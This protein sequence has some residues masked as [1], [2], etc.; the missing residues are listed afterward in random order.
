Y[1]HQRDVY[2]DDPFTDEVEPSIPYSLGVLVRNQGAGVA[3]ALRI[4]S[5]QP[6]IIDNEKGLLIDFNLIAAQVAG[7][8][9]TPSLSLDLGDIAPGEVKLGQWFFTS[10][11][12]GHFIDYQASFTHLD[13]LGI[14]TSLIDEVRIHEM[15]RPVRALGDVDDGLF[16]F[17]VNDDGDDPGLPDTL[18]LSDGSIAPV[19]MAEGGSSFD[20]PPSDGDLE[21]ELRVDMGA[22]YRYLRAPDP[23]GAGYR[24]VAVTRS[25]GLELPLGV[26]AWQTDRTFPGVQ[27]DPVR[28]H[29]LHLFDRDSTGRYTLRYE[30]VGEGGGG[31]AMLPI[32][33]QVVVEGAT[34]SLRARLAPGAGPA[35]F[36]LADG[37]PE[38]ARIDPASGVFSWTPDESQGPG[39]YPVTV[40]A[41]RG[42]GLA[43]G[44]VAFRVTVNEGNQA[45]VLTEVAPWVALAGSP[46]TFEVQAEDADL[47][48]NRLRFT[49]GDEAPDGAT[50]DALSG[51]FSW[52]TTLADAGTHRFDVSVTDDGSPAASDTRR[53]E[54]RL[55]SPPAY[56]AG[57]F[58]GLHCD[59]ALCA[60]VSLAGSGEVRSVGDLP[61]QVDCRD[62]SGDTRTIAPT[63][64]GAL[65]F[66]A[67][68]RLWTLV[69][70]SG[71]GDGRRYLLRL[72]PRDASVLACRELTLADG[73]VLGDVT[74]LSAL[75]AGGRL[76][77]S[78]ANGAVVAFDPL[79][80]QP[81]SRLEVVLDGATSAL[82]SGP[83]GGDAFRVVV[84]GARL[85]GFSCDGECGADGVIDMLPVGPVFDDGGALS[86]LRGL[87]AG[88]DGDLFAFDANRDAL[89][90]I[91]AA[92][93]LVTQQA[94]LYGAAERDLRGLSEALSRIT[95]SG[96]SQAGVLHMALSSLLAG[97]D[98]A[99][100]RLDVATG[101]GV[102]A[103]GLAEAVADAVRRDESLSGA[104]ITARAVRGSL[105]L[106][107]AIARVDTTALGVT[108]E[109][110]NAPLA[111]D[112]DYPT[113]CREEVPPPDVDGDADVDR[114]DLG[115]LRNRFGAPANGFADPL[116]LNHDGVI[117]VLDVRLMARQCTRARCA[118]Q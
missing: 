95:F 14:L 45:P 79:D 82:A 35:T 97:A 28:E 73:E 18:Y 77:A 78:D 71:A 24:L 13:P 113:A 26:D 50:L 103:A 42:N 3:R 52:Q 66:D 27:Q 101:A 96:E 23:G 99:C 48:A 89:A 65:S 47:P 36:A 6:E 32:A 58:F 40:V 69:A 94:A 21:V 44:E 117:N 25:D 100:M 106:N 75:G 20:A 83:A 11:L 37:A 102:S 62:S 46:V 86:A 74:G 53:L 112:E 38:G 4:D 60:L 92:T 17:L 104:G 49:L 90:R 105:F 84:D 8:N 39:V 108:A 63:G 7:Q 1:F 107:A 34:L 118:T 67:L 72:D 91:D 33:D 51:L 56:H 30:P 80:G 115:L 43:L 31:A 59:D 76:L 98:G 41:R 81:A 5:G 93:G 110:G 70:D 9:I 19:A 57:L 55:V 64:A 29:L 87:S 68:G 54:V 10:T 114:D 61:D 116:D 22:G 2:A 111:P 12:Q 109:V 15:L 85:F 16:D 88:L